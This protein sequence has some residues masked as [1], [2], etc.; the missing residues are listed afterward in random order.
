MLLTALFDSLSAVFE[1]VYSL[2]KLISFANV[3][4]DINMTCNMVH[5]GNCFL[6]ID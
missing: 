3:Y 1:V 2:A 4:V 5:N 6:K